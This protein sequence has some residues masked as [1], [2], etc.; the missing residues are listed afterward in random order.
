ML[1]QPL[2][3]WG[4]RFIVVKI[5]LYSLLETFGFANVNDRSTRISH[6]IYA[7][8]QRQLLYFCFHY[9]CRSSQRIYQT[10]RF[11]SLPRYHMHT[12]KH[13]IH[14]LIQ[15]DGRGDFISD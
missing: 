1:N 10:W 15:L 14:G 11:R 12:K 6:E 5:R 8:R 13:H 7:R 3:F 4:V 9:D 2:H